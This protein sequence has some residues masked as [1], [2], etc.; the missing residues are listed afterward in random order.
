MV[1]NFLVENPDGDDLAF[2]GELLI[3]E[4]Y[5]DVGFVKV[6]KTQG[7]R[8]VLYQKRPFQDGSLP[9]HRVDHFETVKELSEVLGHSPGAKAVVRELGLPR[10]EQID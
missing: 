2:D 9:I 8:Y 4:R 3:D 6:W 10:I 7:G 1:E 5:H